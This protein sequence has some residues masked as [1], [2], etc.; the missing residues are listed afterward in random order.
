MN[1]NPITLDQP[2]GPKASNAPRGGNGGFKVAYARVLGDSYALRAR[3]VASAHPSRKQDSLSPAD[4]AAHTVLTGETL[5][6]I[7]RARL[8]AMG[9]EANAKASMQGVRQ[10]AQANNI[11][12]PD[13]IYVGQKL[14]LSALESPFG[15][16]TAQLAGGIDRSASAVSAID[17]PQPRRWEEPVPEVGAQITAEVAAGLALTIDTLPPTIVRDDAAAS[18]DAGARTPL[19]V[20]QVAFYEQKPSIEPT[21]PA[22][23]ARALPDIVYK[24]VVGKVLD[25]MP[26]EPSTRTALQQANALVS[27]TVAARALGALTGI[28]APL[29]TVAGLI[30]GIL[31]ARQIDVAATRDSKATGAPTPAGDPKPASD[32]MQTAQNKPPE[33]F[34]LETA[35]DRFLPLDTPYEL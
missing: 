25:A 24:G 3:D 23:V 18:G 20:R 13:R 6:A 31:S 32:A 2:P 34:N 27:S 5:Y 14:D 21:K 8:V 22:E 15:H 10:L 7:V 11:V 17:Q 19:A 33:A 30:W 26:L 9:V 1:I 28:G 29:L 35:V 16:Q 4:E 12:N